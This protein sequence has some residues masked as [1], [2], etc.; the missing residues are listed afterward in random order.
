MRAAS[1]L[2]AT[3]CCYNRPTV[4]RNWIYAGI[5]LNAVLTGILIHPASAAGAIY[6]SEI[7]LEYAI[8]P[9]TNLNIRLG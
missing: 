3:P 4:T 8:L 1:P 5:A 7:L 6:A 9:D 2:L